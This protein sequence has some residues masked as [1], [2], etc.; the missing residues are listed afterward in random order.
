[1]AR[2]LRAALKAALEADHD[3][4]RRGAAAAAK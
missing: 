1:V 4:E 2:S 3:A